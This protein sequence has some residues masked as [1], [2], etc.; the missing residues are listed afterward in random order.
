MATAPEGEM[1]LVLTLAAVERL[2]DPQAA[3]TDA[4]RWSE[5]IGV[6]GDADRE[7]LVRAVDD[8]GIEPDVVS[9]EG[10][11][12]GGLAALR[13]RFPTERH[14]LVG[15]TGADREIAQA[16]G[17]EYLPL[18]EAAELAGWGVGGEHDDADGDARKR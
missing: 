14:V 6:A 15:G 3:I 7:T 4:R 16:L 11:L 9:G 18:E 10:G 8:A 2:R 17:W 1:T 13:Q 5:H 12:A